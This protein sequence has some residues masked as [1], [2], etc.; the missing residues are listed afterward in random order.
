MHQKLRAHGRVI[1]VHLV[2]SGF[3]Q[4]RRL[5]LFGSPFA[6]ELQQRLGDEGQRQLV[7]RTDSVILG[8]IRVVDGN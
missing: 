4:T 2:P 7:R 6:P 8:N 1:P 3:D 5:G